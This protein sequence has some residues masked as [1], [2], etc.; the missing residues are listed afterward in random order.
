LVWSS[1]RIVWGFFKKLVI[2]D[3]LGILVDSIYN[4]P[5]NYNTPYLILATIFFGFQIYCDLSAYADIALGSARILGYRLTENFRRPFLAKSVTE[6]W[7]KWHIS[8]SSWFQDYVFVPLYLKISRIKKFSGI[9]QEKKHMVTFMISIIIGETLLGIWHGANWTFAAFGFY[10]GVLMSLYY[11]CRKY[12]D[13]LN[14][15]IQIFLTLILTNIAWIFFRS[16]SI[17]DAFYI[18]KNIFYH[19]SFEIPRRSLGLGQSDFIIA[20]I[21][22]LMIIIYDVL[23]EANIS[24]RLYE[25]IPKA[26]KAL[27][28]IILVL[29]VLMIGVY[30]YSQFIYIQF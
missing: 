9:S 24:Q 26:L 1:R 4:N 16:K 8:M 10:Y 18:I 5:T 3:R 30:T 25:K 22:I 23:E 13:S 7:R 14:K 28:F 19:V 21:G 15:Y 6:F 12:W 20:I 29:L 17:G 2:A 27:I 11:L